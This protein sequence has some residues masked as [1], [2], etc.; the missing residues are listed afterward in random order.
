M[1]VAR[2]RTKE[3]WRRLF[4]IWCSPDPKSDVAIRFKTLRRKACL[5]QADLG[6][7]IGVCR[8]TVNEIEN[9][10]VMANSMTLDSF[11]DLEAKHNQPPISS[12]EHWL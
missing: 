8:Q 5:T 4:D 2:S 1:V 7:Y 3:E 12:P 10:R 11:C 9:C 6:H